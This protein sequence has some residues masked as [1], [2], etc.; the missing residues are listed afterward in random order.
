MIPTVILVGAVVRH[1][2]IV[3]VAAVLWPIV[4][5]VWGDVDGV[6]GFAVAGLRGAATAAIGAV[7]GTAIWE[8]IKGVTRTPR[9]GLPASNR[10]PSLGLPSWGAT[11]ATQQS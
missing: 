2:W 3:V 7:I 9:S 1:W 5:V 4:V 11:R 10:R 8:L 6:P